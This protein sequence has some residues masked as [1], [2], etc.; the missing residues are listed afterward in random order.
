VAVCAHIGVELVSLSRLLVN[1]HALRIGVFETFSC[2]APQTFGV[3]LGLLGIRLRAGSAGLLLLRLQRGIGCVLSNVSGAMT[4]S[5][6]A[7]PPPENQHDDH[8][9]DDHDN[10]GNDKRNGLLGSNLPTAGRYAPQKIPTTGCQ[11]AAEGVYQ[12]A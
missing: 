5:V 2:F 10:D 9:D 3:H 6:C 4:V 8:D 7:S 12:S 1:L 11:Q